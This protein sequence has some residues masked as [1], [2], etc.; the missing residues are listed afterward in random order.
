MHMGHFGI[1]TSS[2]PETTPPEARFQKL[3]RDAAVL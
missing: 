3:R 2:A 1:N